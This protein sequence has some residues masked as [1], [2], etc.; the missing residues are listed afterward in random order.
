MRFVVWLIGAAAVG[1]AAGA[2]ITKIIPIAQVSLASESAGGEVSPLDV[3]SPVRAAYDAVKAK[4]TA[5]TSPEQLGFHPSTVSF[6]PLDPTKLPGFGFS[7]SPGAQNGWAQTIAAQTRNFNNQMEDM[8][9]YA[10]NPAGWHG[11]PPH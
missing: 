3:L 2:G 1:L 11:P 6:K 7:V 10:R 8:R 5:G 4:I 9:N